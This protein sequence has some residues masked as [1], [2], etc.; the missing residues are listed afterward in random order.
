MRRKTVFPKLLQSV[1]VTIKC[2][3]LLLRRE[4]GTVIKC[5][6]LLLQRDSGT[7]KHDRL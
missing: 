1:S 6:K 7:A 3:K 2:D 5:D 4:S